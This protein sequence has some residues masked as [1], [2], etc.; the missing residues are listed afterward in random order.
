MDS[1]PNWDNAPEWA[2]WVAM[3]ASG[4]W[5]WYEEKPIPSTHGYW[6][7]TGRYE[8]VY[9]DSWIKSLQPRPPKEVKQ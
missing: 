8:M 2:N 9:G 7:T 4:D 3:D 6:D 5:Y 1:I